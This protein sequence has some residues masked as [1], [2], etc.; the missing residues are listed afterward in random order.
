GATSPMSARNFPASFWNSNYTRTPSGGLTGHLGV[1]GAHTDLYDP[2]HASLHS[3]Q[4]TGHHD[5]WTTYSLSSQA[6]SHRSM[7]HDMYQ[8]A[9]SSCSP[10]PYQQ[11]GGL[12]LQPSL[13]R[14]PALPAVPAQMTM[15]K[16]DG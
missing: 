4:N 2:Y 5:P 1:H 8:A 13:A 7:A 10:R 3:L 9:M 16:P 14:I 11:Y 12:G 6:Y 15:T